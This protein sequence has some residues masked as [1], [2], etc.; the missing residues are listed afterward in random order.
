MMKTPILIDTREPWPHPWEKHLPDAQF[1]QCGLETGD[2]ALAGN[3]AIVV[4]RK[5]VSDFLGTITAGRDRF[6]NELKRARELQQFHIIVEGSMIDCVTERGGM[7][8][9][10]L[11]GTVAAISRRNCPIHF[12]CT[13]RYAAQLAF[14]ILTQPYNEANKLAGAVKRAEKKAAKETPKREDGASLY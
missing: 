14:A 7:T 2:I 9:A 12:A 8:M 3:P 13:E 5:T 6:K 4:E 11:I 10:S 1:V